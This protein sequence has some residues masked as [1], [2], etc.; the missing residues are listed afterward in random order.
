[1]YLTDT[2][3][4]SLWRNIGGG[5]HEGNSRELA[6]DLFRCVP[7]FE[8]ALEEFGRDPGLCAF[9]DH[10]PAIGGD[11]PPD[12]QPKERL[13]PLDPQAALPPIERALWG[14]SLWSPSYFAGSARGDP[15]SIIRPYMEP[16]TPRIDPS[17]SAPD[18]SARTSEFFQ[19]I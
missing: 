10:V 15:L 11:S 17:R 19:R 13:V 3:I 5:R 18:I 2:C 7:D 12:Q 4:L 8:A 6:D 1:M 9:P 14:G 16:H